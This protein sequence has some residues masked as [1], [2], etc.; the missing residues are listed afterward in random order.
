MN[1]TESLLYHLTR[2][3]RPVDRQQMISMV[4]LL[5]QYGDDETLHA[6]DVASALDRLEADG[7]VS[8][9]ADRVEIVREV[10]EEMERTAAGMLF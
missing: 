10:A 2:E 7:R 3:R 9:V 5:S 8:V 6:D 4:C 1:A